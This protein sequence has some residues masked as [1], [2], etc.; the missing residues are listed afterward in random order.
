VSSLLGRAGLRVEALANRDR[1]ELIALVDSDPVVNAVVGSRLHALATLEPRTF[2]GTVLG[3]RDADGRL[4]GAA[5]VGGNLLPIGGGPDEWRTLADA[6]LDWP[7][8]CTSIVGRVA[9][10]DGLWQVLARAWGPPRAVRARQPLLLLE[11]RA[12]PD[13]GDQRVR[14]IRA[15]ELEQYLPAAAAM[16][17][18]ELEISPYAAS[19]GRDYRRRVAGLISEGR[20]FGIIDPDGRVVFKSDLGSVSPHTCQVQGVWVRPELRNRGIGRQALAVVLRH[21]LDLAPTASLYVN[22]YNLGARRVY[23]RLGMREI[24]ALSTILF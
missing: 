14:P 4:T 7:R 24:A 22:D 20:A 11:R 12:R 17:T 5:F 15:E 13:A 16:F 6:L 21:A 9:A 2:G 18:E 19:G 23:D 8:T 10:V 1:G 3:V